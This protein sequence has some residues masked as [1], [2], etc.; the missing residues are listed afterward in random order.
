MDITKETLKVQNK[1]EHKAQ[2]ITRGKLARVLKMSRKPDME[3]YKKTILITLAGMRLYGGVAPSHAA[4]FV[5]AALMSYAMYAG[6]GVLIGVA[7]GNN[8]V[9]VLVGQL[10]Y[11]PSII[12]GGLMVPSSALPAGL[13]RLSL[14][15]PATHS[16]RVFSGLGMPGSA[17]TPWLSIGVL[18]ASI[19]VSFGLAALLFEWD[20]RTQAPSRKAW[21]ALLAIVPFAAAALIGAA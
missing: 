6:I 19:V 7:A 12:L 8:T 9:S 5:A 13:Q 11:I 21:A 4:G 16:M 18:A 1:I 20:S 14:L 17:G 10:I 3:E 2:S 15:L